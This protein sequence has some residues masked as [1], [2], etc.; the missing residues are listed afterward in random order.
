MIDR[1]EYKKAYAKSYNQA[2]RS[3]LQVKRKLYLK[4]KS[5]L[6]RKNIHCD[7]YV[8]HHCFG[9]DDPTRFIYISKQLHTKIHKF[10]RNNNIDETNSHWRQIRDIVNRYKEFKY[11]SCEYWFC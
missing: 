10:L 9:Y 8:I 2:H 7:G 4:A 1:K 5:I 3:E 11:I 6:K